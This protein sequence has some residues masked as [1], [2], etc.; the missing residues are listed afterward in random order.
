LGPFRH[1]LTNNPS[2][3]KRREAVTSVVSKRSCTC[4]GGSSGSGSRGMRKRKKGRR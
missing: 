4:V 3:T 2:F 1:I